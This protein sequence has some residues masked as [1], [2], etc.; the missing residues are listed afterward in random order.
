MLGH[1][2]FT[3]QELQIATQTRQQSKLMF[4][5]NFA[6]EKYLAKQDEGHEKIF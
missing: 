3:A 4:F 2:R 5:E 6:D 1:Y